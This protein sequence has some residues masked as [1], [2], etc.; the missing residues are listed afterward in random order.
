MIF[1]GAVVIFPG[2]GSPLSPSKNDAGLID[3]SRKYF[4]EGNV[5]N[6]CLRGTTC[7]LKLYCGSKNEKKVR[8]TYYRRIENHNTIGRVPQG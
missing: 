7:G 5:I 8:L 6:D 2:A 1:E 3:V 4:A